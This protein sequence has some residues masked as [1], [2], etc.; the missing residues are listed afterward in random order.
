MKISKR[1]EYALRAL[2]QIAQRAREGVYWLQ[3][4]QIAEATEIPEKFLEQI[5]LNLKNEGFLKSRR[6]I[7]GGYSLNLPEHLITLDRILLSLEGTPHPIEGENEVVA[8]LARAIHKAEEASRMQ[9]R[10]QNLTLLVNEVEAKTAS[11]HSF[12]EYQI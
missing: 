8:V 7:S 6:G 4:S 1:S 9:L 2:I 10:S 5:L 11:H 3:I 12:S